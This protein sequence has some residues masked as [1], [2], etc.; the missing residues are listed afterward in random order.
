MEET[1]KEFSKRKTNRLAKAIYHMFISIL[2][3]LLTYKLSGDN[4]NHIK[5]Y[6][7]ILYE[8]ITFFIHSFSIFIGFPLSTA[9]LKLDYEIRKD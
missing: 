9:M 5:D 8:I 1:F 2:L 3:I 6:S 7:N 4:L